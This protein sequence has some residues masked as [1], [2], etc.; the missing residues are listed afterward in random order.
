MELTIETERED[1]GRWIAEIPQIPG[2]MVYGS[3]REAAMRS[4]QALALR[5]LSDRIELGEEP[6]ASLLHLTFVAA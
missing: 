1:D 3:T 5:V 4:V 6:G 2:A